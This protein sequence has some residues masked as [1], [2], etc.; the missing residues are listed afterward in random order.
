MNLKI[1]DSIGPFFLFNKNKTINWSRIHFE[2]IEKNWRL[3]KKKANTIIKEFEKFVIKIKEIGYN[4]IS[5]DDLAH[6]T[7]F[8]F[9]N[10]KTKILLNDYS[11]FFK[12]LFLIAKKENIKILINTDIMFFNQE[13]EKITRNKFKNIIIVFKEA[14][15]YAFKDYDIDGIITRIGECDGI[16]VTSKFKSKLTIKSPRQANKFLKDI[17]PVIEANNKILLFRTWTVG[18]YNIGDLIWN[19]NT[20]DKTFKDIKSKNLIISMKPGDTDFFRNIDVNPLFFHG[21]H[22]KILELQAKR[23]REFNGLIP[24]YNGW[25]YEQYINKLKSKIVGITVWCQTGGWSKYNTITFLKNSSQ[26]NELN[27]YACLKIYEGHNPDRCITQIYDQKMLIFLKKYDDALHSILYPD[28]K[29]LYFR[30]ARIPNLSW[31]HWDYIT[32]NQITESINKLS[33]IN[34]DN[35]N[36]IKNND[37]NINFEE[38]FELGKKCKI[39]NIKMHIESLK[40]LTLSKQAL[41]DKNAKKELINSIS[42]YKKNYPDGINFNINLSNKNSILN[43]ILFR[44]FIRTKSQYRIIDHILMLRPF[45]WPFLIYLKSN[46]K[47]LPH[48]IN[49][50]AMKIDVL[51]K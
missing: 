40:I 8:K 24:Y 18:A 31:V 21:S 19:K 51:F 50:Q 22:M 16:D 17:L 7:N 36:E 25:E 34:N 14:L 13:I 49:K 46:K 9:Y 5:I 15:E 6:L 48:F 47:K 44:I 37:T 39:E 12:K 38:L 26:W 28:Q 32:I 23:E 10:K 41:H 27:T 1:I 29:S 45:S 4:T 11:V 35:K 43:P 42:E 2:D 30:R 3:D 20:Y 33:K